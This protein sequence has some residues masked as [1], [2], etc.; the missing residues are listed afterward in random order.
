MESDFVPSMLITKA[1]KKWWVFVLMIVGGVAGML[2]TRIH[3]PVFQSQAVITTA[4]D[5]AY[6]GRLEDYEL[7]HLILTVGDVIDSTQVKQQVVT[8]ALQEIPGISE[9]AILEN[10]TPIRKGYDWILSVRTSEAD[11]AQ[12]IAQWWAA[13]AMN[14]LQKMSNA[15][16]EDFH[17][18]TAMLS[19]ESC[20]SQSVVAENGA[21]GCTTEDLETLKT[22][23]TVNTDT[24][25]SLRD[26]ILLS[27]LSFEITT[28][29]ELPSS[30][31]LFRQNLNVA[32][33]ALIGLIIAL[34]WFFRGGK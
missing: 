10:L 28:E 33:G 12:K 13:E 24:A 31:I 34:G 21:S 6:A 17:Q 29:P 32:A 11:S 4:V 30:P 1:V 7:D 15:A 18:Q 16:L 19:I 22:Y 27:N 20:F 23:L 25:E 5:Y 26:S 14:S 2:V 9:K 3:K 8:R